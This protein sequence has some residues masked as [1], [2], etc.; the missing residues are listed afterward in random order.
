[1][2]TMKLQLLLLFLFTALIS[3]SQQQFK[4]GAF[5]GSYNRNL[6]DDYEEGKLIYGFDIAYPIA[7]RQH[8]ITQFS[9][10]K[11][12]YYDDFYD[13]LFDRSYEQNGNNVRAT[14]Y[15]FSLLYKADFVLPKNFLLN[16]SLGA[17]FLITEERGNQYYS[18]RFNSG[19]RQQS[20][21]TLELHK[22]FAKD[23]LFPAQVG[24]EYENNQ[25]IVPAVIASGSFHPDYGL[26]NLFFGPKLNVKIN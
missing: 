17:S 20:V 3:F 14:D 26:V 11:G 18:I 10:G 2:D 13:K 6:S 23:L 24:F 8:L 9:V 5:G 12:S 21:G 7:N 19:P 16:G 1:M 15:T 25:R 4:V 22:D